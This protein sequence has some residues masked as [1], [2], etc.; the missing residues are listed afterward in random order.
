MWG[1]PI[2]VVWQ[3]A[4]FR[5][6]VEAI[7]SEAGLSFTSAPLQKLS[8]LSKSHRQYKTVILEGSHREA[9]AFLGVFEPPIQILAFTLNDDHLYL[10]QSKVCKGLD[11]KLLIAQVFNDINKE[12]GS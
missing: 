1:N 12:E 11:K 6:S 2:L 9:S 7:L 5:S 3:N 8:D 10:F 4:L